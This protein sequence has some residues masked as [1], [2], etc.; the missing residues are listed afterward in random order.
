MA[1]ARTYGLGRR[2]ARSSFVSSQEKQRS[3]AFGGFK[4]RSK[5]RMPEGLESGR[6]LET[7][8]ARRR[9]KH[10]TRATQIRCIVQHL[11]SI[12]PQAFRT[13][14]HSGGGGGCQYGTSHWPMR[15]VH[16]SPPSRWQPSDIACCNA[17]GNINRVPRS[18]HLVAASAQY[19]W[20]RSSCRRRHYPSHCSHHQSLTPA[21]KTMGNPPLGIQPNSG[22]QKRRHPSPPR[23][24][25]STPPSAECTP[26]VH[27][28]SFRL[29]MHDPPEQLQRN[30]NPTPGE[31]KVSLEIQPR[32]S[33]PFLSVP[34]PP[35]SARKRAG[36]FP[37][38]TSF[39][40]TD[41]HEFPPPS[42]APTLQLTTPPFHLQDQPANLRLTLTT[43][44]HLHPPATV[45]NYR[46]LHLF[47]LPHFH[48]SLYLQHNSRPSSSLTPF[49]QL[50]SRASLWQQLGLSPSLSIYPDTGEIRLTLLR[51]IPGEV[52]EVLKTNLS[53]AGMEKIIMN[54]EFEGRGALSGCRALVDVALRSFWGDKVAA[55]APVL[56]RPGLWGECERRVKYVEVVAG[57]LEKFGPAGGHGESVEAL[58]WRTVL[59]GVKSE[60]MKG[61][62]P[63]GDE[64][65]GEPEEMLDLDSE[66]ELLFDAEDELL[67][68]NSE[69][70]LLLESGAEEEDDLISDGED[71]FWT[72]LEA[73]EEDGTEWR[74][75]EDISGDEMLL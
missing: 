70:E 46:H 7:S 6:P 2:C 50:L 36:S 62:Q 32:P 19:R 43:T 61:V 67:Y 55:L 57:V 37:P 72:A 23:W 71:D 44:I 14:S 15:L 54:W 24:G 41:T 8:T 3:Q 45:S 49:G 63:D 18:R 34:S 21:Q 5:T 22:H 59:K 38:P 33:E 1:T 26:T 40:R 48:L 42:A 13:N 25:Y 10:E 64:E 35:P 39:K 66:Q 60:K 75:L 28:P 74:A 4:Y 30:H 53:S 31:F 29:S 51:S 73:D 52:E 9:S 11:P 68:D 58:L 16:A 69:D 12:H 47:R 65:W 27:S 20:I 56:G 17:S